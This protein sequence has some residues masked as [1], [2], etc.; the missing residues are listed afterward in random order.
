[1]PFHIADKEYTKGTDR[2]PES[3]GYIEGYTSNTV[4]ETFL[5]INCKSEVDQEKIDWYKRLYR[6][7]PKDVTY[8]DDNL[9]EHLR[10]QQVGDRIG[11]GV[12]L[13]RKQVIKL[14]IELIKWLIK[15]H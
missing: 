11:E 1:M 4:G 10:E 6:E 3:M 9:R 14:V 7:I 13:N 5:R 2:K 15:R 8:F 12:R